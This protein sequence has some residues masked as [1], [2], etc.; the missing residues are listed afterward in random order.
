MTSKMA[1]LFSQVSFCAPLKGVKP[2]GGPL[3]NE[4]QGHRQYLKCISVLACF[5]II[6]IFLGKINK[7]D[8][9][10]LPFSNNAFDYASLI[11]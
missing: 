6:I 10:F 3:D 9:R 8:N 1:Q 5:L 11:Q 4:S 2:R 7:C